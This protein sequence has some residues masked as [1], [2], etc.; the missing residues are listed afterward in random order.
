LRQHGGNP[1]GRSHQN[2]CP[3][4]EHRRRCRRWRGA[5]AD[6]AAG[7]GPQAVHECKSEVS[8]ACTFGADDSLDPKDNTAGIGCGDSFRGI[9]CSSSEEDFG[10]DLAVVVIEE[11]EEEKG[12]IGK[13][14]EIKDEAIFGGS[15]SV[16]EENAAEEI[17]E[18][19]EESAVVLNELG[20]F[21]ENSYV[22]MYKTLSPF[23]ADNDIQ[24]RV[25]VVNALE[26]VATGNSISTPGASNI[27]LENCAKTH[28]H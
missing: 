14:V 24:G 15:V 3:P 4:R 27:L 19:E 28:E 20:L 9:D 23:I 16:Q 11:E 22:A 25:R 1:V 18:L 21:S 7:S 12:D 6:A 5:G 17:E 13:E 8:H 26:V 10:G 2:L